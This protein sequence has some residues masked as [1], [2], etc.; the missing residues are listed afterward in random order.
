MARQS[1]AVIGAG[2]SGLATSKELLQEGHDVTCYERAAGLGGVFRFSDDPGSIGVW[3]SCRLTSSML[4]TS[5]S[6]HFP[7][8]RSDRPYEHRQMTHTEYVEYLTSYAAC[9]GV[10]DRIRFEHEV[11]HVNRVDGGWRVAA[12]ALSS[13]DIDTSE[14]DAVAICTGVHAEP[15]FPPLLGLH[16][17]GGQVLHAAHYKGPSS[18]RGRSAVF[19]GAGES[20][21]DI[22]GEASHHLDSAYVSLRRGA[23]VL[24]RLL[25][26]L[27]ND[28]TGTR[29]LYSLPEFVSRRSD[30]DARRLKRRIA[31]WALPVTAARTAVDRAQRLARRLG[32]RRRE[33]EDGI[34]PDVEQAIMQMRNSAGGNQFETF[35]TKTESFIE[36]ILDGRCEV[37]P[38]LRKVTPGGVVFVDGTTAD[39]DTIV[40]CTGFE[41][42]R[43]D[44]LEERVA[45]DRLYRSS[46]SPA[47]GPSLAFIGFLRPPL[48]AIPPMSEMQARWF[49]QLLSGAAE[50][51]QRQAMEIEIDDVLARRR[52]YH[53]SVYDRLPTLVDYSTY[54]DGLAA[55][56][57]C[58]PRLLSLLRSPR[59][60]YK[61][62]TAPFSGAQYRLRG[63][64]AQ[65][66]MAR[67]VLLYAPSHVRFVR[68]L[69]LALAQLARLVGLRRLQPHLTLI[70]TI[71][72]S[73]NRVA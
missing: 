58:K 13:G 55:L 63:P 62:Y 2:P 39:V 29:L 4:V 9:F 44:F 3:P 43:V 27:P 17:F 41:P 20:G 72:S 66:E 53:R 31:R 22:I 5:F 8:W 24:P 34:R 14:F 46:F 61:V 16:R 25:H 45:I 28:Y 65:P 56:V 51:P 48:G 49:A 35:A 40:L 60:M 36:A 50:L 69:D 30:P 32:T 15:S 70:G 73:G 11:V 1:V 19:V 68:F 47:I 71:D 37:R 42:P 64:H 33:E 12:R 18:I 26:G 52:L 54:M 67:A 6:D 38:A 7:R 23:F 10:L 59:L 21:G 57:G